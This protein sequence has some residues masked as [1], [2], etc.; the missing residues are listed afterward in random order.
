MTSRF[1]RRIALLAAPLALVGAI[2]LSAGD[3]GRAADHTATISAGADGGSGGGGGNKPG[4]W[5]WE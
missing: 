4:N 5:G 1:S 2:S 3:D